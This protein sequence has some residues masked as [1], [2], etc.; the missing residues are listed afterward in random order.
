MGFVC[1]SARRLGV[2]GADEL[3][4]EDMGMAESHEVAAGKL[5]DGES[6]TQ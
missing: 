4:G 6:K 1:V 2:A 3:V 5:L